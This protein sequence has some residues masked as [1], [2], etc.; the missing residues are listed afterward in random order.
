MKVLKPDYNNLTYHG[1]W[2]K[3]EKGMVGHWVRPYFEFRFTGKQFT[4]NTIGTN[5]YWI[6]IGTEEHSGNGSGAD[7][8]R[9]FNEVTTVNIRV[10]VNNN[11]LSP[12]ILKSITHDGIIEPL[13]SKRKHN[14]LFIGDSL[15]HSDMSYS[16]VI[17]QRFNYDYT[18]VAQGGLALC[19]GRGYCEM[20]GPDKR[21]DQTKY[22]MESAFYFFTAPAEELEIVPYDFKLSEDYDIVFLNYGTNDRLITPEDLPE[23]KEKYVKLVKEVHELYPNATFYLVQPAADHE[24]ELRLKTIEEAALEACKISPK[25]NYVSSKGWGVEIS[26]D[27]V[28]PTPAGYKHFAEKLIE[29]IGLE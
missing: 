10:K 22:G 14:C 28:H 3:T 7:L 18:V 6:K 23:F 12:F 5:D 17:P 4:I 16:V 27:K 24:T 21:T 11:T 26:D 25:I 19:N 1:R 15:T 29:A 13:P 9:I 2:E 8:T 20:P